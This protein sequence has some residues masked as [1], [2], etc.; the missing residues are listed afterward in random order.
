MGHRG[1]LAQRQQARRLR[2]TGPPLAEIATRLGVS[3]SSVSLWVR[4]VKFE[5]LPRPPRGTR[6]S[7]SGRG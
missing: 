6:R 7:L 2:R 4:D 1:K 5:T 3:K